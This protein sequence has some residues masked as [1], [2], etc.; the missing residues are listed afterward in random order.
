M[1]STTQRCVVLDTGPGPILVM[2]P[3]QGPP[4]PEA[5]VSSTGQRRPA[6]TTRVDNVGLMAESFGT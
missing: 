5:I 3:A 4:F 6:L 1:A 2:V